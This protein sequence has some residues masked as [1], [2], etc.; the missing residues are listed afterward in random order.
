MNNVKYMNKHFLLGFLYTHELASYAVKKKYLIDTG[1]KTETKKLRVACWPKDTRGVVQRGFGET[2]RRYRALQPTVEGGDLRH[3]FAH[4]VNDTY[5]S[6]TWE[7]YMNMPPVQCALGPPKSKL[8]PTA[9]PAFLH[10][11]VCVC[12]CGYSIYVLYSQ[13]YTQLNSHF[14]M[15]RITKDRG[16]VEIKGGWVIWHKPLRPKL[17][18]L[19]IFYL[20]IFRAV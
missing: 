16:R 4:R 10:V 13:V 15:R 14:I 5:G 7:D 6:Q 8:N 17:F 9:K 19:T 3:W 1:K 11:H 18:S 12:V 20:W 2:R